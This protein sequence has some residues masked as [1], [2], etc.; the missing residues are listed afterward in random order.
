MPDEGHQPAF[1]RFSGHDDR[2][3]LLA[4]D[5]PADGLALAHPAL[6]ARLQRPVDR[7]NA[8]VSRAEQVRRFVALLVDTSAGSPFITPTLKLRRDAFLSAASHHIED[9]YRRSTP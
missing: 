5:P 7:A 3:A 8:A 4:Q 6:L 1:G 2:A 9:L